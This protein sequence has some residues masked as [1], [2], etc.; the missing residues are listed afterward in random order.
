MEKDPIDHH[1]LG[2]KF[3]MW[4]VNYKKQ[5]YLKKNHTLSLLQ[6]FLTTCTDT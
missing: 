3:N 4:W 2:R 6:D 1:R 5:V